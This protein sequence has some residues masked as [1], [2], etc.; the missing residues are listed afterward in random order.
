ME[1]E[2]ASIATDHSGA[3]ASLQVLRFLLFKKKLKKILSVVA[4]GRLHCLVSR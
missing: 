4:S 3:S 1:W 2:N